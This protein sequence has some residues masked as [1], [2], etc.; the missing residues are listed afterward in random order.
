MLGS[1]ILFQCLEKSREVVAS[2]RKLL[3]RESGQTLAQCS[4]LSLSHRSL[5]HRACRWQRRARAF[6]PW[7]G[8]EGTEVRFFSPTICL[9]QR[10]RFPDPLAQ[11]PPFCSA[12]LAN[13]REKVALTTLPG[14]RTVT[15]PEGRD[16]R[17]TGYPLKMSEMLAQLDGPAYI[18]R[19]AVF[20]VRHVQMT[21]KA[22]LKA[23]RNQLEGKGFSLVEVVAACPTNLRISPTEG[24]KWVREQALK[25]FPLG[26]LK[27]RD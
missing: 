8:K 26:D 27:V 13:A 3:D 11:P 23:F 14:M 18:T 24:N 21:K 6:S 16:V 5:D 1:A 15:T 19:Q 22:V 9:S 4:S 12:R 2:A 20:D 17:L 25:Y 7:Q 10:S